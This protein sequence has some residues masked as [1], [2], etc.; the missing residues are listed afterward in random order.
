MT[1]MTAIPKERLA[2]L[3]KLDE[4]EQMNQ[5]VEQAKG[6]CNDAFRELV[7]QNHQLVRLFVSRFVSCA[8]QI[9][10]I[11]QDVFLTAFD[12]LD[13]FRGDSKFSTW[14]LGIARNKALHVLRQEMRRKKSQQN[15]VE[16][17]LA[18]QKFD[19]LDDEDEGFAEE[20]IAALRS[21]LG[22]L[23]EPSA[24]L[25]KQFYFDQKSSIDIAADK[26]QKG[27][28]VRMKLLRI[29]K[30]LGRCIKAELSLSQ[31]EK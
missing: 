5:L 10:D 15:L 27:S 17:E 8:A 11:S 14:L 30:A 19:R 13:G 23:P 2:S 9:E 29:R 3:T 31:S 6:G 4:L 7:I 28:A 24:M 12:R 22:K 26:K 1:D 25:V 16:R 18:K 20:K 21:C